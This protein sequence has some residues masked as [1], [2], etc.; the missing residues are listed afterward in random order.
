M[1][2]VEE[3]PKTVIRPIREDDLSRF[4]EADYH[5]TG[6]RREAYWQD[7]FSHFAHRHPLAC[8]VAEDDAGAMVGYVV[9]D[10]RG[11]EYGVPESTG[12]IEAINVRPDLQRA[13]VASR[14]MDQLLG[15]FKR[16]GVKQ[17]YCVVDWEQEGAIRF[18]RSHGFRPGDFV[19]FEKEL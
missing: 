9:G 18:F 6:K 7:R 3:T 4:I 16:A 5:Q 10:V 8:L 1:K 19:F 13:G 14:L 11:W 12:W 17:V 2:T 15:Y